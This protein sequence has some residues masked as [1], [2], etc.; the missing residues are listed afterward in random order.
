M[1]EKKNSDETVSEKTRS[2]IYWSLSL[3]IPYEAFRFVIS[4]F[5]ARLLDPK[6]FGIVSI[7][8]MII[9]YSNTLT[10]FGFNHALVQKK[11]ISAE[12]IHSVFTVDLFISCCMVGIF[13]LLAPAIASFFHSPESESVIRVM[14]LV[15]IIT[16]LY[17]LPYALLR[18]ELDFKIV[19][20]TDTAKEILISV[21]TLG[22]AL[23]GAKYWA[24]VWGQLI[25]LTAATILLIVKA[26][27][28]PTISYRHAAMKELFNFGA[29]SFVRLQLYFFSS[30]LDRLIV[31]RYLGTSVLGVYDKS[32]SLS[33]MPTES[34]ATNINTVLFSSFSRIQDDKI[35]IV[36]MLKKS[37]VLTSVLVFPLF[38]GLYAVADLFVPLVLGNK[39]NAMILPLQ[40]MCLSGMIASL[41][42]LFSTIAVGI[43]DYRK[44]TIQQIAATVI[45]FFLCILAVP[46]GIESVALGVVLYSIVTSYMGFTIIKEKIEFSWKELFQCTAPAF[47]SSILMLTGVKV[48]AALIFRGKDLFTFGALIIVGAT[49]YGVTVLKF[50]GS[51]LDGLRASFGR[52]ANSV[53]NKIKYAAG[54]SA[55]R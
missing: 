52:D 24:I 36:N 17:D 51:A 26:K 43:G 49:L 38:V 16:T 37:L 47:F 45:L 28:R 41:N 7:A 9:F 55:M 50:P 34:I 18:R 2:G 35:E 14:S 12:H 30:R 11:E 39:W 19:S 21:M 29:W 33:Q 32:K 10:N 44:Y 46:W 13:Y 5:V 6:D 25:P 53:W 40:I 42:G 22:L 3:K 48:T 15:F 31:G 27:W 54:S 23:A 4:I 1:D 20:I 8:S